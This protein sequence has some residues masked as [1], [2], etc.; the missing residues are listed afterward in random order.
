MSEPSRQFVVLS[1][2]TVSEEE[3]F[4]SSHPEAPYASI[5]TYIKEETYL[6]NYRIF[7]KRH[8]VPIIIFIL[9]GLAV[10]LFALLGVPHFK[11]E[12]TS[13]FIGLASALPFGVAGYLLLVAFLKSPF[14]LSY[15]SKQSGESD[16]YSLEL[17]FYSDC[18]TFHDRLHLIPF[19]KKAIEIM[20]YTAFKK[21]LSTPDSI[22]LVDKHDRS[23]TIMRKD[24]PSGFPDW[25]RESCTNAKDI[26]PKST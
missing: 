10:I 14:F 3:D 7:H 16:N 11:D 19:M 17:R 26:T 5:H 2:Y 6:E 12:N 4:L 1:N 18:L 21:Y 8:H 24:M 25:I 23:V 13:Y 22:S 15:L 9:I 20:P